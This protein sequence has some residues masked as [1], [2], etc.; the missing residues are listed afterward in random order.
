MGAPTTVATT[1]LATTPSTLVQTTIITHFP[2]HTSIMPTTTPSTLVQ[3]TIIT[4][5]PTH[6]S[7]RTVATTLGIRTKAVTNTS[8]PKTNVPPKKW[9][10][11]YFFLFFIVWFGAA[12]WFTKRV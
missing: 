9:P 10:H 2:T 7:A 3:T 4:H 1:R 11:H 5:F 8:V 12:I 6:T